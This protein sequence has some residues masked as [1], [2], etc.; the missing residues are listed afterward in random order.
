MI[1]DYQIRIVEFLAPLFVGFSFLFSM[2]SK[3]L[4]RYLFY[5]SFFTFLFFI[6]FRSELYNTDTGNYYAWFDFSKSH[7][8]AE[9]F[10]A[11]L[12][13]IHI[14]FVK[15]SSN[16]YLWF[17][18]ESLSIFVLYFL[19][20]K[21]LSVGNSLIVLGIA[22]PLVSSS[23]RYVLGL[24]LVGFFFQ[25]NKLYKTSN[26]Y[27]I[28]AGFGHSSMF[29][30][31]YMYKL[32]WFFALFIPFFIYLLNYFVINYMDRFNDEIFEGYV[33]FRAII[34]F[35]LI[36]LY[37][38]VRVG[39]RG[40]FRE[41][42]LVYPFIFLIL[43]V[44]SNLIFPMANRWLYMLIILFVIDCN[45]NYFRQSSDVIGLIFS[46][47][48]YSFLVSPFIF[49]NAGVLFDGAPPA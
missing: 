37:Y 4:A 11:K 7:T 46:I 18:I 24:L 16:I 35:V 26:L 28:F 45:Q 6:S 13:P 32:N 34:V 29:L 23:F 8:L 21:N 3:N 9:I 47:I 30:G 20:S 1:N 27:S 49:Y 33:G 10:I 41:N 2:Y 12:E 17:L 25:L 43:F 48:V 19:V 39:Y 42:S 40:F 31:S 38:L 22:I 44:S 15:I 5:I 14:L 36:Y